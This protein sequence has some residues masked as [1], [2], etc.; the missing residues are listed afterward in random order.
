MSQRPALVRYMYPHVLRVCLAQHSIEKKLVNSM[1]SIVL[2]I[3]TADM[4]RDNPFQFE[5]DSC[6]ALRL[7]ITL[8]NHTFQT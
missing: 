7:W 1:Y 3:V 6:F 4:S 8:P 2:K 5:L